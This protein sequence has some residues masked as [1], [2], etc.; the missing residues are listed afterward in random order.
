MKINKVLCDSCYM[1]GIESRGSVT[2]KMYESG[3]PVTRGAPS[4]DLTLD[5]CES[6]Y[7]DIK[8]T[9]ATPKLQRTRWAE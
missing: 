7:E 3:K 9:L 8:N 5:L 2:L 6:C 4:A 1:H